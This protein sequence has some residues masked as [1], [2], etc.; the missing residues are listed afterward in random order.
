[1][2]GICSKEELDEEEEIEEELPTT[3][4]EEIE[5]ELTGTLVVIGVGHYGHRAYRVSRAFIAEDEI[6]ERRQAIK[7]KILAVGKMSKMFSVLRYVP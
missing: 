7:N 1:M 2:L 5:A 3:P 6:L 4:G